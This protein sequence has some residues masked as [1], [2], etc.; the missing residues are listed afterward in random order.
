MK[1]YPVIP[2]GSVGHFLN[3]SWSAGEIYCFFQLMTLLQI[4]PILFADYPYI[5]DLS[6][7]VL[8]L[9]SWKEDGRPMTDL[10]YMVM[11]FSTSMTNVFPLP[12]LLSTVAMSFALK[13]LVE[14]YFPSPGFVEC[15]VVLP[16]WF[17]PF[18]L[19]NLSYQYDA[20]GMTLGLVAAI[21]AIT[22]KPVSV[23]WKVLAS[24]LLIAVAL[25][26]YQICL[27]VFLGLAC[28]EI[29]RSIAAGKDHLEVAKV[30]SLRVVQLASGL[31][32][33][34]ATAY[35]FISRDRQGFIELSSA[36]FGEI[37]K[38]IATI[39]Q[40]VF[41]LFNAANA[42]IFIVLTIVA[43]LS[44][45]LTGYRSLVRKQ[46]RSAKLAIVML[47]FLALAGVVSAVYGIDLFVRVSYSG[48]RN[49][50]GFSTLLVFL[51]L[52]ARQ[53]FYSIHRSLIFFLAIPLAFMLSFSFS[54]G[55]IVVAKKYF[56]QIIVQSLSYDVMSHAE[57]RELEEIHLVPDTTYLWIPGAQR[58]LKA[59][60]AFAFILGLDFLILPENMRA[61]GL[62]NVLR[63]DNHMPDFAGTA[64]Y[65]HVLKSRYYD[66]YTLGKTG[67]V[68]MKRWV[69]VRDF[70]QP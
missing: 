37:L 42:W 53:G 49:L 8:G 44:L 35:Q 7:A 3:R 19:Q 9:E 50:M 67:Y 12:L 10:L 66:I 39:T 4:L 26:F 69:E 38:R 31:I 46:S 58:T 45:L 59:T 25:S 36:G 14:H 48:A 54:Y 70:D 62:T 43:I 32:I 33:Y 22:A 28:I 13:K 60:P 57:I 61:A 68:V 11:T 5:D 29:Y 30:L 20:P 40:H 63:D 15:L 55:R 51:M 52:L 47:Y 27:N 41:L 24:A 64:E 16:L 18:F 2:A 65:Q 1:I 56:E 23:V 6:R 17:S 21:Y 34:C